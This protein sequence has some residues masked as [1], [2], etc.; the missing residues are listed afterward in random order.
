MGGS[1]YFWPRR[2]VSVY[3]GLVLNVDFGEN[4]N[5]WELKTGVASLEF[6]TGRSETG[7]AL[8]PLKL[9]PGSDLGGKGKPRFQIQRLPGSTPA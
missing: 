1:L 5:T 6:W 3:R 7:F 2:S 8:S 4:R 9:Q